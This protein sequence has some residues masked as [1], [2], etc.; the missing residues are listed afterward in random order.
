MKYYL[1]L[2]LLICFSLNLFGQNHIQDFFD[3]KEQDDNNELMF[4]A[5]KV[6]GIG[7]IKKDKE[8]ENIKEGSTLIVPAVKTFIYKDTI[9]ANEPIDSALVF[10]PDSIFWKPLIDDRSNTC[11]TIDTIYRF[12]FIEIPSR[13][14]FTK[15]IILLD[16]VNYIYEARIEKKTFPKPYW[17]SWMDWLIIKDYVKDIN[18]YRMPVFSDETGHL[19]IPF[20]KGVYSEVRR[21]ICCG[22]INPTT[23]QQIRAALNKFGY[24]LSLSSDHALN[25]ADKMALTDFQKKN[26]L[27]VGNL[28]METLR[29]LGLLY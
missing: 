27:P 7:K 20:P 26:G 12:A 6:Y 9:Y 24:N 2:V 15:D 22:K 8:E 28:N 23:T 11:S 29:A 14:L 1:P 10:F 3:H 16:S 17:I 4:E 25:N 21:I 18:G 13:A 5:G 19:F